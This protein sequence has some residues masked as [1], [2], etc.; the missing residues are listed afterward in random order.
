MTLDKMENYLG[1]H[2]YVG[3]ALS[4]A[5]V[6]GALMLEVTHAETHIPLVFMQLFQMGA[7]TIAMVA[8]SFTIYGVW[9]THHSNKRKQK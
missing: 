6:I 7:W 9:K 1:N 5:H 8:G 2:P 4:G 3:F